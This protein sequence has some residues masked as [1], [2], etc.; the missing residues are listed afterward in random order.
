VLCTRGTLHPDEDRQVIDWLIVENAPVEVF[1]A[2][3]LIVLDMKGINHGFSLWVLSF[4]I[5]R[6]RKPVTIKAIC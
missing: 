6:L 4:D 2:F 3:D 1:A 5:I